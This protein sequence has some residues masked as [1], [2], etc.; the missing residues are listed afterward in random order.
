M[1]SAPNALIMELISEYGDDFGYIEHTGYW[2]GYAVFR[3]YLNKDPD[4]F[5]AYLVKEKEFC[6]P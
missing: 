3:I 1:E 6:I 2:R 4:R 5:L